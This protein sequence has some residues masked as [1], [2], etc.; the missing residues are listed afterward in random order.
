MRRCGDL[1]RRL[2]DRFGSILKRPSRKDGIN[3]VLQHFKKSQIIGSTS[4]HSASSVLVKFRIFHRLGGSKLSKILYLRWDEDLTNSRKCCLMS[5]LYF[6][7]L[8]N[9]LRFW[10]K[11]WKKK[12]KNVW[13]HFTRN[14]SGPDGGFVQIE[15]LFRIIREV[16]PKREVLAK[17]VN[18]LLKRNLCWLLLRLIRE[19]KN[20]VFSHN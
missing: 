15:L 13:T 16:P 14:N 18:G 9:D 7:K 10:T 20:T 4:P 19:N 8:Q 5:A 1:F 3:C 2:H 17:H 12:Q 6:E 11:N